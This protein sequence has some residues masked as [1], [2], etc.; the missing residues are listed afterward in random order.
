M[1]TVT[2]V[3]A[4]TMPAA[5]PVSVA[6]S[7]PGDF[8]D[9]YVVRIDGT[10]W[11]Y[12][13]QTTLGRVPAIRSTDLLVWQPAGDAM[14]ALP[15]WAADAGAWAPAA[16]VQRNRVVLYSALVVRNRQGATG[17]PLRCIAALVA[18]APQGPFIDPSH[19]PIV[20]Q[21]EHNGSIDPSV[22]VAPGGKP[23]LLWKS[24]GIPRRE[25]PYL[26]VQELSADGLLVRG[27]PVALL[28][29]DR[30]WEYPVIENP[31][32]AASGGRFS[33]NA[34]TGQLTVANGSL[35]DY[36]TAT[37]HN[38]TVHAADASGAFT[39]ETFT[40][41]VTDVAPSQPT[42]GN[43][44]TNTVSEGAANGDLV[45]ITATSS[46]VNGGTVTFSLSDDAGGRFAI[47]ASTGV[48]TVANASLLDEATASM[49]SGDTLSGDVAFRLYD[50]YGFPRDLTEDALRDVFGT[51]QEPALF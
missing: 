37:S 15:S 36:E 25:P 21:P 4:A 19:G 9:P 50:T 32:M 28:R 18:T 10:Y 13:T 40:I 30:S 16:L 44:A 39:A 45:G 48:V 17:I 43:N 22:F 23:Y 12:A 38:I 1:A 20:C 6:P 8:P 41:A 33:I 46:D 14:P 34:T 31:A 3:L 24:E 7:W 11:A 27:K 49:K 35:L 29:A 26:W 5:R 2:A 47:D 42:D 51:Y